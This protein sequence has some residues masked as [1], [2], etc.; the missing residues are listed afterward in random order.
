MAA[1]SPVTSLLPHSPSSA[2]ESQ[3]IP[4]NGISHPQ[5]RYLCSIGSHCGTA[6]DA[7]GRSRR[8]GSPET[9]ATLERAAHWIYQHIYAGRVLEI[10]RP[11]LL[12]EWLEWCDVCLV[13]Y[14]WQLGFCRAALP[15]K[16]VLYSSHN[17]EVPTR[18]SNGRAAGLG[19]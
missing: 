19:V 16:P 13:E 17:V 12:R 18:I 6:G 14:P 11:R 1:T 8:T 10:F 2:T 3:P 5:K 7:D 15:G 9:S 4:R